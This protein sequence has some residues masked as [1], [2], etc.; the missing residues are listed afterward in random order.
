METTRRGAPLRPCTPRGARGRIV[1]AALSLALAGREARAQPAAPAEPFAALR[2]GAAWRFSYESADL[3][4]MGDFRHGTAVF[5]VDREQRRPD[6]SRVL[7]WRWEGVPGGEDSPD[8][9]VPAAVVIDAAGMRLEGTSAPVLP[10]SFAGPATPPGRRARRARPARPVVSR[11]GPLRIERSATARDGVGCF[12]EYAYEGRGARREPAYSWSLCFDAT[13]APR[14]ASSG[15]TAG[16]TDLSNAA[17]LAPAAAT[18]ALPS[19]P[20]LTLGL[21]LPLTGSMAEFGAETRQGV[22]LAVDDANTQGGVLGRPL[23]LVTEDDHGDAAQAATVVERLIDREGAVAILGEV[24]SALSLAGARVCQQR[25]VPMVS[26]AS[27]NPAVT[28]VGDHIFRACFIDPY[29]GWAMADFASRTL[30][31]T[32]VAVLRDQT[33]AYSGGLADAFRH[34]LTALGGTVVE[35]QAYRGGDTRFTAQLS[36]I[37]PHDPEAIFVPG[38]YTEVALLAREARS[39]GFRGRFL[40]GDGWSSTV[41]TQNDDDALVGDLFVDSYAVEAAATPEARDFL[42]RYRARYHVD[43]TG[44]AALGY[45]AARLVLDALHR[46]GTVDHGPL[47]DALAATRDLAGAVGALT[48]NAQRDAV[49]P[50]VLREVREDRFRYHATV[51]P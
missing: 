13:G 51:S 7:R 1:A 49:R 28:Q 41:L 35:D 38:Y 43:P 21:Y 33:S 3:V 46:A 24:A 29:Q 30:H 34:R 18:P 45:D 5:R 22:E 26:P 44:L 2:P 37:V 36:A 20:G 47:R 39:L 9:R 10:V 14:S 15:T 4:N 23:R 19:G 50:V 32:R 31:F 25:Q 11:D 16:S 8:W 12:G 42:Q 27:T 40:G 48:M 6:G 17:P